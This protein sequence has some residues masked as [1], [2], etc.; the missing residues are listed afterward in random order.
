[1]H[2]LVTGGLGYIGSHFI[3]MALE[4]GIQ[5][6]AIDNLSNSSIQTQKA[7]EDICEKPFHFIETDLKDKNKLAELF[8][9]HRFDAVVHFAGLKAVGESNEKPLDYYENNMI[10]SWNLL[11][12]MHQSE[13]KKIIFSSSATVYGKPV[14]NPYTEEHRKLPFNPY[15]QTKSLVEEMMYDLCQSDKKWSAIAL[16][17]FNPIGAHP[18]GKIGDNPKGIPNNLMPY[19]TKVA[20]GEFE[21]LR[22]FGNDYPTK[23][24]TGVRDYIHVMDLVNG[25]LKTL[26]Y[27]QSH[28]GFDAFNLGTGQGYSVLEVVEAFEK[29]N[30]IHIPLLFKPRRAGDLAAYWADPTKARTLLNWQ[31]TR[32]LNEMMRDAWNWQKSQSIS[33]S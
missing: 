22:V 2:I 19:I 5:V 7:I 13:V 17:Y 10:G 3:V 11:H 29:E 1:M 31:T 6:T 4:E 25:H 21:A 33:F 27:Q 23:D 9:Q 30:H 18:S 28:S 24:G 14:F 12:A 32:N 16:R 20:V 26:Q 8:K 15:G